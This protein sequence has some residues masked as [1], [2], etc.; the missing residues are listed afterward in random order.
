MGYRHTQTAPLHYLLYAVAAGMVAGAWS[1]RS[2]PADYWVL[3][4]AAL[5][6][7]LSALSFQHLTVADEGDFLALRY[8]PLPLFR[9]H[10]AYADI[11]AVE[12]SRS[13]WLD[14]WGIHYLPGRGRT[15][16]LWG[17]DCAKLRL[18]RKIIRVGSDD[19]DHLVAFL[20]TKLR[21]PG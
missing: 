19:A 8:G 18:G 20:Q 14:G 2:D 21:R 9:K 10:I 5:V 6:I 13:S 16:N 12:R 11:T 7:V 4:G 15:Y 17:F 1:C 3:L